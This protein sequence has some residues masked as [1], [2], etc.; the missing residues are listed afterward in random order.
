MTSAMATTTDQLREHHGQYG[1]GHAEPYQGPRS[2]P[3]AEE[4]DDACGDHG[5]AHDRHVSRSADLS[6][7]QAQ[8]DEA[9]QESSRRPAAQ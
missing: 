3:P 2:G 1:E 6:P 4:H 8:R 9:H 5:D 7:R